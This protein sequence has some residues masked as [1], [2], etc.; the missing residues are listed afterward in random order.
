MK[1]A[2]VDASPRPDLD[3]LVSED[4]A[5][6]AFALPEGA[7]ALTTAESEVL[8]AIIA[9]KSNA[10]IGRARGTSTRTVANQVASV[11]RKLG[12]PSRGALVARLIPLM[13]G[14]K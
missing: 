12:A 13:S 5:I 11:L 6:F 10:A 4:E 14:A 1:R 2:S 8:L 9:G 3:V 7:E